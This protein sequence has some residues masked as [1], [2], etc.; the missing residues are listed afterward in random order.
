M[1]S[2]EPLDPKENAEIIDNKI[3]LKYNKYFKKAILISS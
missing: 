3:I 1:G 2:N